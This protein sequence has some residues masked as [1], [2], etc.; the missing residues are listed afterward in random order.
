M[1]EPLFSECLTWVCQMENGAWCQMDPDLYLGRI[2]SYQYI[3]SLG[4]K[5]EQVG[6]PTPVSALYRMTKE[7]FKKKKGTFCLMSNLQRNFFLQNV[8]ISW[9]YGQ[10]EVFDPVIKVC[11]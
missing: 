9:D 10:R 11:S 7:R 3:L 2:F 1:L 6:D 8:F 4:L 5:G